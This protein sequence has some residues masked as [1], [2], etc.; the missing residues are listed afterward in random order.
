MEQR[1]PRKADTRSAGQ[2][3]LNEP[4]SSNPNPVY[5]HFF[6]IIGGVGLSP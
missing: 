5:S 6:I 2:Y 4:K 3:I 1:N